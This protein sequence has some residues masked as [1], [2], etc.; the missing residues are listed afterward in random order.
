MHFDLMHMIPRQDG[1][2]QELK[3]QRPSDRESTASSR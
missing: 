1:L 2:R 3:H